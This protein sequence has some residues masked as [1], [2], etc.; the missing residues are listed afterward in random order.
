M[1]IINFRGDLSDISAYTS[2]LVAADVQ[3]AGAFALD[4]GGTGAVFFANIS[5]T[6]PQNMFVLIIQD[7]IYWIKLS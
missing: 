6:S 5:V 7:N 4:P 1:K 3:T 2:I